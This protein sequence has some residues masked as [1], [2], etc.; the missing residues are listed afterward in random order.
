[1]ARELAKDIYVTVPA[2]IGNKAA[3]MARITKEILGKLGHPGCHSGFNIKFIFDS[4]ERFKFN[5]KFEM[6]SSRL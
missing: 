5:E 1:M 4:G 2:E 6:T 3:N